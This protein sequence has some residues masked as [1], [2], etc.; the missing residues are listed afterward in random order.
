MKKLD[1]VNVSTNSLRLD[2]RCFTLYFPYR[3]LNRLSVEGPLTLKSRSP[4]DCS[5]LS[6]HFLFCF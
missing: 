5:L 2:L 6:I 1:D 3:H 4:M